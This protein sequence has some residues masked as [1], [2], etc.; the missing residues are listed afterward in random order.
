MAKVVC[1]IAMCWR[2][3]VLYLKQDG[4][5]RDEYDGAIE[6]L[7]PIDNLYCVNVRLRWF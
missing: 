3:D 5:F 7:K 6:D 2:K 4:Q 1:R